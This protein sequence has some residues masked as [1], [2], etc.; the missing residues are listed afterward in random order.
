MSDG[1]FAIFF[2]R[3]LCLFFLVA[4]LLSLLSPLFGKL[5]KEAKFYLTNSL[6][7]AKLGI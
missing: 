2:Q 4:A 6:R 1:S 7:L 5:F 3:P